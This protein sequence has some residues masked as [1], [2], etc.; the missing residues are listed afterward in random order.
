MVNRR[1]VLSCAAVAAAIVFTGMNAWSQTTVPRNRTLI[2]AG[3]VEA[4]VYRN[5]GLANPY[6]INNE[7]YRVSIINMF[8]P[9]FYYNSNKNQ[10]IPWLATGFDYAA[11]DCWCYARIGT[12]C[13]YWGVDLWLFKAD[14]FHHG[15][16]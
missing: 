8:E 1:T 6:S 2:V 16:C 15:D 3:Q 9:L 10:V 11:V 7:D 14:R 13:C 5:V 12:S 4:P